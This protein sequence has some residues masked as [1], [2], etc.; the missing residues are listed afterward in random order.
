MRIAVFAG[1]SRGDV[2]PMVVLGAELARRGHDVVMA[3][4]DD[5]V[6]FA[7]RLGLETVPLGIR[8]RDFLESEEGRRWLADGDSRRFFASMLEAK[9]RVAPAIRKAMLTAAR[10]AGL[11]V[12]GVINLDDAACIAEAQGI[13]VVGLH[14]APWRP[15]RAFPSLAVSSRRL[16]APVN[17]LT[18][19]LA[20][21]MEWKATAAYVNSFRRELGLALATSPTPATMARAGYV[22]VQA[23]SRHLVPELNTWGPQR[24]LV[25]F[26]VPTAGQRR[27]WGEAETDGP[28]DDW[29]A[30]GEPPVYFGFG[31]MP[32]GESERTLALIRGVARALGVRALVGAGW[33]RYPSRSLDGDGDIRVV[34]A[35]DHDTV[36]PR[37]QAAVHHG[38]G[39]TTATCVR[40]GLPAV[41]CSFSFDQPFWGRRL[42][43]RGVGRLLPFRELQVRTLSRALAS[44]LA[45]GPRDR[46]RRLGAALQAEDAAGATADHI[47]RMEARRSTVS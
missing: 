6:E 42:E 14:L 23:F 8:A 34:G 2:Q 5:Q 1:G 28:L 20:G 33:A 25:G 29:L 36:L 40:A 32:V 26:I 4:P 31:S 38:G 18:H 41:V 24:P 27:L 47:E 21:R 17:R 15:N 43:S 16:P 39:G 9:W 11:I 22:E 35:I 13:P 3:T 45:D 10:D 12:S 7:L 46:A 37:C 30:A 19:E 44:L